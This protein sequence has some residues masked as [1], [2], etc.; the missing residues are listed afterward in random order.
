MYSL[1]PAFYAA[2]RRGID[3]QR[4]KRLLVSKRESIF[5]A[6]GSEHRNL[7]SLDRYFG[8]VRQTLNVDVIDAFFA[9]YISPR[10]EPSHVQALLNELY[11]WKA[12]GYNR[13]VGVST[14]NRAIALD[15]V[16]NRQCDVLMHRYNMAHRKAETDVFPAAQQADIPVVAFTCTRWGTLLKK[17]TNW[18]PLPPTAADCYRFSLQHPAVR[19]ALTSPATQAELES[20]LESLHTPA[21]TAQKLAHWQQFGDLVYGVG[22]DAFET[23]WL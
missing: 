9:E 8:Q 4:L 23:Q 1:I 10:D 2:E 13:Y 20:N 19:V 12:K 15:L 16:K 22:Q 21:L 17:P 5:V 11:S 14:H 6:T 7:K 18:I 3:P